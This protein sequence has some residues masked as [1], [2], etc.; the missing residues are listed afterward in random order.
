M[1]TVGF[2]EISRFS[3]EINSYTSFYR[4][5]AHKVSLDSPWTG[6]PESEKTFCKIFSW[7]NVIFEKPPKK[8]IND[9][10]KIFLYIRFGLGVYIVNSVG[11]VVAW[12]KAD[13]SC[14]LLLGY[15]GFEPWFQLELESDWK[16]PKRDFPFEASSGCK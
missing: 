14:V 7:K 13:D 1:R 6:L 5:D 4:L 16:L 10:K 3:A 12:S 11:L 2:L 15:Q 9:R 8:W